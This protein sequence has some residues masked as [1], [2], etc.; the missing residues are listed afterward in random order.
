MDTETASLLDT[1]T[2]SSATMHGFLEGR[3]ADQKMIAEI[4]DENR[5][6]PKVLLPAHQYFNSDDHTGGIADI[7]QTIRNER[8][9]IEQQ[10]LKHSALLFRG[11]PIRSAA[12]F[13]SFV[14]AFGW[15]EEPYVGFAPRTNVEDRVYT[16]NEG[17][18][19]EQL[20]FHHEMA[21]MKAH[22]SKIFFFCETAP[23][24]G[25]Q[26]A[27]I[28]SQSI[29]RCMENRMP[30]FVNRL[31]DLGL[32]TTVTTPAQNRVSSFIA[33][34]WQTFLETNDPEEAK[35]R[36]LDMMNCASFEC[37]EDGSAKFVLGPLES[38]RA[39]EG[40]DGRQV[41]FYGIAASRSENIS[42]SLG[43]GSVIPPEA[44]E[45][46]VAILDE[47]CVNLRW[48]EGDVLLV[49]NLAVQHGKRASKPPRRILVSMCK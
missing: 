32:L 31:K 46:F 27:I 20:G 45:A 37:F 28:L 39:F 15:E 14:E 23:P 9:W 4:S 41:W 18:L 38:I 8:E 26:T 10:L 3:I 44:I 43:D 24:E 2:A 11:F 47:E 19:H 40:Y 35:K 34:N 30:E 16:A 33:K 49:D 13:S 29:T 25:G 22:P 5:L 12:D 48:E 7:T 6:F 17:P 1:E 36:A 42:Q 21:M